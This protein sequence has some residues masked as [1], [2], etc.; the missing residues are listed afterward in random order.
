MIAMSHKTTDQTLELATGE[1][2]PH[3]LTALAA[4]LTGVGRHD[5]LDL[6]AGTRSLDGENLQKASPACVTNTLGQA[7][8]PDQVLDLQVFDR[9]RVELRNYRLRG[10]EVMIPSLPLDLKVLQL[11]FSDRLFPALGAFFAAGHFALRR[12][13]ATFSLA[14]VARV[15]N[16]CA[17]RERGEALQPDINPDRLT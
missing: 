10:F 4:I 2:Q 13:Q 15:L 1:T 8:V 14:Q 6:P 16:Y 7:W 11:Q 3:P 17:R 9:D 12:L 5:S